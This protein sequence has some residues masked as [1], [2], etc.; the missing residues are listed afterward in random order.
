M[1]AKVIEDN[2]LAPNKWMIIIVHHEKSKNLPLC[3]W[4]LRLYHK[5]SSN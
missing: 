3:S 4:N 2:S 1:L 5:M